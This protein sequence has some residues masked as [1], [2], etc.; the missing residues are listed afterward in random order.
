[1][2]KRG[3][4]FI[5][6]MVLLMGVSGCA[7]LETA[8]HKYFMKGHILEVSGDTAYLCIGTEDGAR[9]G[10]EATVYRFTPTL[11]Q[12]GKWTG[13]SDRHLAGKVKITEIVDGHYAKAKVLNGNVKPHDL[14]TL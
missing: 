8:Q 12:P 5:L 4:L 10:Q 14:A 2:K 9:V 7:G 6:S 11:A 13:S 3:I 1:M